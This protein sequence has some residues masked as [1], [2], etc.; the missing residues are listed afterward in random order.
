[1]PH[2]KKLKSAVRS[3]ALNNGQVRKFLTK[4]KIA[5]RLRAAVSGEAPHKARKYMQQRNEV[6]PEGTIADIGALQGRAKPRTPYNHST[7]AAAEKLERVVFLAAV[8]LPKKF[9][10]SAKRTNWSGAEFVRF[11][12]YRLRFRPGSLFCL[13]SFFVLF[14]CIPHSR[15][16]V[17]VQIKS[18]N[19]SSCNAYKFSD[20]YKCFHYSNL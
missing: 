9:R 4:E 1:M 10:K 6:E 8:I 11:A 2:K 14:I 19:I 7:R 3:G 13:P 5:K 18:T 15:T 16:K 12:R 17:T 20:Q